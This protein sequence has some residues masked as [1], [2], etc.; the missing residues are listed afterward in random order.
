MKFIDRIDELKEEYSEGVDQIVS[1]LKKIY[2][3]YNIDV[4][5]KAALEKSILLFHDS[6]IDYTT[7]N[8]EFTQKYGTDPNS[9]AALALKRNE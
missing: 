7:S 5:D 9:A 3:K 6:A 1:V 4:E 8:V 2:T